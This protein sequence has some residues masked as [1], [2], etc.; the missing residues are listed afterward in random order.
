M[1]PIVSLLIPILVSAVVV[2]I[3]SALM[4]MVLKYHNSDYGKLAN[5]EAVAN[6]L[7]G[8]PTGHFVLPH[9][10]GG[11]AFKDPAF[12]ER[13]TRG[14]VAFITVRPSG[15]PTMGKSLGLWFVFTVVTGVMAA[16]VAGRV[17]G[18]GTTYLEV[19][20]VVGTTA[21]LAYA[22]GGMQE[23]IWFGRKWGV[24]VKHMFDGL[25]YALLTAGVF[26]WLW[27]K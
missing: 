6:A 27:P 15:P 10:S 14:P 13:M 20:R 8:S 11:E 7:R 5:E 9:A 17:L 22:F 18:P 19:F 4:H 26:G 24:T 16:Y 12:I 2:F 25:V 21:F 23:S 1:V 3:A